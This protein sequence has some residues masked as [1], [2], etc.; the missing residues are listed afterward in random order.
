MDNKSLPMKSARG[1]R[2]M[3]A[4]LFAAVVVASALAAGC[5][6]GGSSVPPPRRARLHPRHRRRLPW[7]RPFGCSIRQP[8]ALPSRRPKS[9]STS[10]SKPG[11]TGR[12]R[13]GIV[14]TDLSSVATG[15]GSPRPVATQP[16]D[17]WFRNVIEG[18]DQ[19]RQ[20][21]AF[22]LSQILVTSEVGA[23]RQSPYALADYHD[24]LAGTRLRQLS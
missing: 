10:A 4:G 13:S 1:W 5:G 3:R 7:P 16:V 12:S 15:P 9:S 18:P 8:S 20:R 24:L 22:A 21:V 14:A 17:R 23:L 2:A 6:G 19:L 11:S